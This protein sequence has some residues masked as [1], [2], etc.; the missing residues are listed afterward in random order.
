V[1]Q[2]E[3]GQVPGAVMASL[4]S[5]DHRWI[6]LKEVGGFEGFLAK[7]KEYGDEGWTLRGF[8]YGCAFFSRSSSLSSTNSLPQNKELIGRMLDFIED[9]MTRVGQKSLL[10]VSPVIRAVKKELGR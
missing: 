8:E 7:L 10:E 5:V 3:T 4:H 9:V 2:S 1:E 6:S